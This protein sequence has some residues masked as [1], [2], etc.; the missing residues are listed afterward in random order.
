[1]STPIIIATIKSWNVANARLFAE[2]CAG[3][4]NVTIISHRDE[5]TKERVAEI[6]PK[7]IFIPHWSWIIPPEIHEKYECVLF[8]MTDLPYGR[9]G[10]PL[11]NLIIK[12]HTSTMISALRVTNEL[13]AG[14]VYLKHPLPLYG[15][16]EEIFLRA[17]DI[18]F[19]TMIPIILKDHPTPTEQCGEPTI[20][21]RRNPS[22]SDLTTAQTLHEVY[23]MIRMLDAE[24]YPPAFL[25]VNDLIF[26]FRRSS[27]KQD[28][29]LADVVIR[30]KNE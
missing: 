5:F 4:Y 15:T 1:M 20:F 10:S 28:S 6:Q 14:P 3:T 8:H 30:R 12:G 2:Q 23:D 17:S 25:E 21:K 29:I 18:I 16:A 22:D 24:G 27:L 26:E 11:Q 7:Y 19:S 9:G 13:D